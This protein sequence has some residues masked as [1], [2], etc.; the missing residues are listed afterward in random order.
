MYKLQKNV[1]CS[2]MVWVCLRERDVAGTPSVD[3]FLI[4]GV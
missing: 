2:Y 1:G 4:G 3:T